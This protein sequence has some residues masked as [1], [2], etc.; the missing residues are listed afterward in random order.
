MKRFVTPQIAETYEF[1]YAVDED[2]DPT[3][4]DVD[5]YNGIIRRHNISVSQPSLSVL[6]TS[7]NHEV[8][9]QQFQYVFFVFLASCMRFSRSDQIFRFSPD[10][11]IVGRWTDFVECGPFV[12][13]T[14]LAWRSCVWDL[15]QEDLTSGWGLD[16]LWH[17]YCK[18]RAGID[19]FAVIDK[20]PQI[21]LSFRTASSDPAAGKPK[22]DP[23]I[24]MQTFFDRHP[25]IK[26]AEMKTVSVIRDT[27]S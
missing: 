9:Y 20:F 14:S 8:T 6:S 23:F 26:H 15:I 21:H 2:S 17:G 7:K 25:T 1:I 24:E 16:I 4:L 10:E 19:R 27:S 3:Q 22:Y 12:V 13:V 18:A 11:S 5:G